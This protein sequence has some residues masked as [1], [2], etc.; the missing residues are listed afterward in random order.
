MF[1]L[2]RADKP[3]APSGSIGTVSLTPQNKGPMGKNPN[4]LLNVNRSGGSSTI[5]HEQKKIV[6]SPPSSAN[7]Q[8]RTRK[9]SELEN[10]EEGSS[11]R[12]I[13]EDPQVHFSV[14]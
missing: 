13:Y 14:L 10:D 12:R 9:S 7:H 3:I 6:S 4:S 2:F 11:T 5:G 1:L 8:E